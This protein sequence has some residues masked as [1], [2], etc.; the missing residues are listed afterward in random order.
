VHALENLALCYQAEGNN[1]RAKELWQRALVY[2]TDDQRKNI[3]V[4]NYLDLTRTPVEIEKVVDVDTP[5]TNTRSIRPYGMAVI[6]GI[7]NYKHTFPAMYKR[8]DALVFYDYCRKVLG[9]DN[10]RRIILSLDDEATLAEIEHIFKIN[11]PEQRS[12]IE[13]QLI[14]MDNPKE[15]EIFIYLGGH[16]FSDINT[17]SSYFIPH[18]V[19]P[20]DAG[21]GIYL[22]KLFGRLGKLEVKGI[23]IFVES[24]FSG[25]SGYKHDSVRHPL[26]ANA[27]IV[28]PT[29]KGTAFRNNMVVFSA[30]SGINPSYNSEEFKH[31]IFTYYLLKGLRGAADDNKDAA[32]TV[33]ELFQYI[34]KSV[35]KKALEKYLDQIPEISLPIGQIRNEI[36][37]RVLVQF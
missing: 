14:T 6:I 35:S 3:I 19:R 24:C 16:G 37:N 20:G 31:G 8:R 27:N 36:E 18:D 28:I 30:T 11:T 5:P 12:W 23:Y 15:A 17:R 25:E 2:E 21:N 33:K 26:L 13:Q 32:I 10:D 34:E 7:E 4:A 22:Q 9:I 29:I 1:K